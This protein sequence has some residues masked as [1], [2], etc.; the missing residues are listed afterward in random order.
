MNRE[1][2]ERVRRKDSKK[3]QAGQEPL[4]PED[5]KADEVIQ[6][7][8]V[9]MS[10]SQLYRATQQ[11]RFY[12]AKPRGK[13]NGRVYPSWQFVDPVP[14]MLPEVLRVLQE[15]GESR[16]YARMVTAEDALNELSPAEVLAGRPFQGR[17]ELH[18]EQSAM[19]KLSKAER[20]AL[21]KEIFEEPSREHAIG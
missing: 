16:I 18:S 13:S 21:V 6:R 4:P 8:L 1:K 3:P 14:D 9:E 10:L 15:Q 17:S 12:C 7:G 20:L 19:L 11:G 2:S 5:L